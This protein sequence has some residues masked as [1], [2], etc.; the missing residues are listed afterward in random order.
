MVCFDPAVHS[1]PPVGE[2]TTMPV[3]IWF[4][5]QFA[6]APPL[7]PWQVQVHVPFPVT[8]DAAPELQRFD[9][10]GVKKFWLFAMPQEPF[11][12]RVAEQFALAPFTP[13]QVQVQGPFPVTADALPALQRFDVGAV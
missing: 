3:V 12:S 4:A 6:L 10:G 8:V 7:T 9:A 1:P 11:T 2:T 5:E 13:W